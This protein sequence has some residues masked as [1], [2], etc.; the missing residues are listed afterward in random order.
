M[1]GEDSI[2]E[3]RPPCPV[4][5]FVRKDA[6]GKQQIYTVHCEKLIINVECYVST[7]IVNMQGTWT[8]RTSDRLSCVFAVPTPG[9]IMNVTLRIGK[10][11]IVNT[12]VISK[13]DAMELI[14]SV[15][16]QDIVPE[17]V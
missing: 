4:V 7:A 14:Q 12:A 13:E 10:D 3:Y 2:N 15:N 11:R 17:E 16:K 6:R 8:N 5:Y 1:S 9:T